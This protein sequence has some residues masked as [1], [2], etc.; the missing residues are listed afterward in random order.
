MEKTFGNISFGHYNEDSADGGL[1]ML[2]S[3]IFLNMGFLILDSGA[4]SMKRIQ[5]KPV[6]Y[7]QG[8]MGKK[9]DAINKI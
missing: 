2:Q 1:M 5:F 9:K 3:W 8:T 7:I 6:A 4:S